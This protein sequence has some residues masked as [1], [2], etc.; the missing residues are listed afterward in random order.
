M[1]PAFLKCAFFLFMI[2]CSLTSC[3]KERDCPKAPIVFRMVGYLNEEIDNIIL[4]KYK[5]KSNFTDLISIDTINPLKASYYISNVTTIISSVNGK[6]FME[7]GNEWVIKIPTTGQ[8][9]RL[10][11][12]KYK[13]QTQKEPLVFLSMDRFRQYCVSPLVS[14]NINSSIQNFSSDQAYIELRK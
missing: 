11:D 6:D 2:V 12:F 10:K 9:L 3:F 1:K 7:A 13:I 5:N 4:S 14:I 8:E